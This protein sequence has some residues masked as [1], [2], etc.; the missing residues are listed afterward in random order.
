MSV[1]ISKL[2]KFGWGEKK[3]RKKRI[4]N[5]TDSPKSVLVNFLLSDGL[6]VTLLL[7]QVLVI[8]FQS[9][10]KRRRVQG[11]SGEK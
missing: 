3:E 6:C 8:G 9:W 4:M 1:F 5:H 11:R 2:V 7:F 10:E